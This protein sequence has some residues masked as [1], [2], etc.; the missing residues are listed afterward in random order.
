[1]KIEG[2]TK[3]YKHAT[4]F[5]NV[6]LNLD[7]K[8]IVFLMGA[9]G[10][11]KTTFLKC[12]LNLEKYDGQIKLTEEEVLEANAISALYEGLPFYLN[13]TGYQNIRILVDKK[14]K[15]NQLKEM[16]SVLLDE[17]TLRQKV[18]NYSYGQRKKLA[19]LI[20]MLNKPGFIFMDEVSGGLDYESIKK[21]KGL[22]TTWAQDSLVF[23]TG[24]NF[25]FYED[26]IDTLLIIKD[27]KIIVYDTEYKTRTNRE[28]LANIY[29]NHVAVD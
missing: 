6:N 1:M 22:L 14:I 7:N 12:V 3:K 23:L 8:Q 25:D 18:Q 26:I 5:N 29:E 4:I 15:E 28:G 2:L 20:C 9:N 27:Q 21:L 11:G 17:K 10:V 24:Q 13:L 19:I 16:C